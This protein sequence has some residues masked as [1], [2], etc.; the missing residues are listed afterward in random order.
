MLS[1]ISKHGDALFK[2]QSIHSDIWVRSFAND[3]VSVSIVFSIL[4]YVVVVSPCSNHPSG[5][6]TYSIYIWHKFYALC[7]SLCKLHILGP[8]TLK[9]LS[10]TWMCSLIAR[11]VVFTVCV[12]YVVLTWLLFPTIA[13]VPRKKQLDVPYIRLFCCLCILSLLHVDATRLDAVPCFYVM[14]CQVNHAVCVSCFVYLLVI[15]QFNK[16]VFSLHYCIWIWF[17]LVGDQDYRGDT[18]SGHPNVTEWL[19]LLMDPA[20]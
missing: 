14:S 6:A 19:T 16:A 17:L 4:L 9:S 20:G 11:F 1:L 5:S 3:I 13:L 12:R 7:S 8:W 2:I 18:E 10:G 15:V